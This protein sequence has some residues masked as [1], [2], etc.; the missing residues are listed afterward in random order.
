VH[1]GLRSHRHLLRGRLYDLRRVRGVR[2]RFSDRTTWELATNRLSLRAQELRAAGEPLL[3]LTVSNPTRAGIAYPD[4]AILA[5]LA[6][7]EAL[8]YE[9]LPFGLPAAREAVA[10]YYQER[11]VE[12]APE[13]ILLT[14]STS[15]AYSFLFRLLCDPFDRVLVPQPSYPLF[16][17]LARLDDVHVGHWPLVYAGE[18]TVDRARLTEAVDERTRALLVV[19]PNNPTGS[20]LR[21]GEWAAVS[22][23]CATRGMAVVVDEVFADYPYRLDSTTFLRSNEDGPLLF[24]LNGLSKVVGLPQL[25]LGWVRVEGPEALVGEALARLEVVADTYLSVAA[26]VQWALPTL[27]DVGM[28]VQQAIRERTAGGRSIVARALR[29]SAAHLLEADGGWYAVVRLPRVMTDEEWAL[30][31]LERHGVVVQPGFFFDFQMEG[32]AVVSVLTEPDVLAEGMAR[33]AAAVRAACE[34]S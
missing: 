18:W 6:R 14:A 3:D 19:N 11:G 15:E 30:L 31:L 22:A 16:E 13:R 9:P 1:Q 32:Y 12:V 33:L 5:A 17:Y 27:L 8:R 25:K 28:V 20:F 2:V 10:R 34:V 29:G 21:E 23:L 24:A 7:P 4:A 26:P